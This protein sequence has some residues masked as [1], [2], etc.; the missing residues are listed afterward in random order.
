MVLWFL[1]QTD[2]GSVKQKTCGRIVLDGVTAA[3]FPKARAKGLQEVFV[4]EG[5]KVESKIAAKWKWDASRGGRWSE[6][7]LGVEEAGWS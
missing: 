3:G 1:G 5:S 4:G 7:V 6:V 2:S